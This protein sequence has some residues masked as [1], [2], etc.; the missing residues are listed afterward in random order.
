MKGFCRKFN[1][2]VDILPSMT[3]DLPDGVSDL[4]KLPICR[5]CGLIDSEEKADDHVFDLPDWFVEYVKERFA[6]N[7]CGY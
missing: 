5:R 3:G 4:A 2:F 1:E 6:D 7:W